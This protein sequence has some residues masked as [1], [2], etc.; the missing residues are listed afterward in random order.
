MQDAL[1]LF[2]SK[3]DNLYLESICMHFNALQYHDMGLI[4]YHD[5][6]LIWYHDMC[7]IWYHDMG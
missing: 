5:M 1:M 2:Q 7:L 3:T 6:G 4:W